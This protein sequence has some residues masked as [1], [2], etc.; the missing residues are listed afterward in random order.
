MK[1]RIIVYL[2]LTLLTGAVITFK[3]FPSLWN[4]ELVAKMTGREIP[5][6]VTSGEGSPILHAIFDLDGNGITINSLNH[7]NILFDHIGNGIRIG[8]AWIGPADALLSIDV[9]ENGCV[10]NGTELIGNR[11]MSGMPGAMKDSFAVLSSMDANHD[12]MVDANDPG[13]VKLF[14]WLDANGDGIC[15]GTEMRSLEQAGVVSIMTKQTSSSVADFSKVGI[16]TFELMEHPSGTVISRNFH[17]H[18]FKVDT[19]R[20]SF[21]TPLAVSPEIEWLPN[22]GGSGLVRDLHE[23][24]S[25]SPALA[26]KLTIFAGAETRNEQAAMI[27]DLIAEWGKTSGLLDMHTRAAKHGYTI[28][29]DLDAQTQA[30]LNVLEQFSGRSYFAFPWEDE[31]IGDSARQGLIVGWDGDPKHLKIALYPVHLQPLNRAY[32]TLKKWAY[33]ELIRQ[34]RLA[35]YFDAIPKTE[36]GGQ[37]TINFSP[38]TETFLGRFQFTPEKIIVDLIEFNDLAK[39]DPKM[40]GWQDEG[41]RLL[42]QLLARVTPSSSLQATL[43]EF[44]IVYPLKAANE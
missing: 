30:M 24:A 19:F 43:K 4:Y 10:D 11:F 44:S 13:Y 33:R 35:P 7:A 15:D 36:K 2:L 34:T 18:N 39:Q 27:E 21:V 1:T 6:P 40:A 38:V 16:G 17:Q 32:I 20:R 25:L 5:P 37:I 12:G 41:S 23:A 42:N 31:H 14:L 9:N 29:T 8:S 28:T 3:Y 26:K 22:L